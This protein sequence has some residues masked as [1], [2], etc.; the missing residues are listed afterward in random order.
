MQK[1]FKDL[2]GDER[3]IA[4]EESLREAEHK[5]NDQLKSINLSA[6]RI[7]ILKRCLSE[8]ID[9]VTLGLNKLRRLSNQNDDVKMDIL[10]SDCLT[11][12]VDKDERRIASITSYYICGH[13]RDELLP[14]KT[15][16]KRRCLRVFSSKDW[17]RKHTDPLATRQSWYCTCAVKFKTSFGQIVKIQY[18]ENG[19]LVTA[20]MKADVPSWDTEDVR[21]MYYESDLA[22]RC[23]TPMDLYD[24]V[25]V[26][27]PSDDSV[28]QNDPTEM[29]TERIMPEVFDDLPKFSWWDIFTMVNIPAPK[30]LKK[31]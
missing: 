8:S 29:Q 22:S 6:E 24:I 23:K 26:I 31:P 30:S 14:D 28:F 7:A 17:L 20:Y 25:P 1:S 13:V 15:W 27:Y 16:G 19:T 10:Y 4:M 3:R 18:M 11:E 9:D 12:I 5:Y 21:A 2:T